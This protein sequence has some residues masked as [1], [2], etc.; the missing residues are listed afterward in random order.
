MCDSH[1]QIVNLFKTIQ[2]GQ[3]VSLMSNAREYTDGCANQ[4]RFAIS[5]Y[6]ITVLPYL[7]GIIMDFSINAPGNE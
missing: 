6:L 4:Y 7:Y 2:A 1:A 3:F 5:I